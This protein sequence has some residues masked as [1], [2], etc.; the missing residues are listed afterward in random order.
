M[1]ADWPTWLRLAVGCPIM[2]AACFFLVISFHGL[3][4]YDNDGDDE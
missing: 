3:G 1:I 4:V 2:L